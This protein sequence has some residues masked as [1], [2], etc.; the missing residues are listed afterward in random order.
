MCVIFQEHLRYL[1]YCF[2]CSQEHHQRLS[3]KFLAF[4][5]LCSIANV[6]MTF[7]QSSWICLW[8]GGNNNKR[9]SG[10]KC[11]LYEHRP[12]P[13]LVL[14][15]RKAVQLLWQNTCFLCFDF[16]PTIFFNAVF[17]KERIQAYFKKDYDF[18]LGP[19]MSSSKRKVLE[20][21]IL[22]HLH[23]FL[24]WAAIISVNTYERS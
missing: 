13:L 6:K 17:P 4:S 11:E 8:L 5:W 16:F 21:K 24:F 7:Q 2:L 1:V 3:R 23:V 19:C 20:G 15:K 9:R 18:P 14:S 12:V 22:H 10:R